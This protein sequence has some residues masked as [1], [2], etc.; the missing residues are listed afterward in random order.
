MIYWNQEG[1]KNVSDADVWQCV[2]FCVY[3]KDASI[4]LSSM[5]PVTFHMALWQGQKDMGEEYK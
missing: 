2:R 4:Y 1:R 3:L 5:I